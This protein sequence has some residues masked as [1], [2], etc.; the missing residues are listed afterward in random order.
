MGH[1]QCDAAQKTLVGGHKLGD[2]FVLFIACWSTLITYNPRLP[3]RN[4]PAGGHLPAKLALRQYAFFWQ[5]MG[6]YGQ[7]SGG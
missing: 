1:G 5:E 2:V 7:V 3:L 4:L 6:Y